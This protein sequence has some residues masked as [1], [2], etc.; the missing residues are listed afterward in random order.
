M[1]TNQI[2]DLDKIHMLRRGPLQEHFYK[3]F[4]RISTVTQK[5]NA[6]F[7]FSHYKSMENLSY[8]SNESTWATTI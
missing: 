6:N 5:I 1:A 4:V 2:N 7:H 3:T 8:Q